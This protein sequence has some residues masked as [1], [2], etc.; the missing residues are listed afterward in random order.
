MTQNC[1]SGLYVALAITGSYNLLWARSWIESNCKARSVP[2]GNSLRFTTENIIPTTSSRKSSRSHTLLDF[3]IL[4][5]DVNVE[6]L[7]PY[8]IHVRG[9]RQVMCHH[10]KFYTPWLIP[11][12]T[13]FG[14]KGV[15]YRIR[16]AGT[17][18]VKDS[19]LSSD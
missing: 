3:S 15:F 12:A 13:Q 6:P 2:V 18:L 16:S 19:L 17:S 14:G 9:V 8:A 10:Q 5:C 4:W 11:V 7:S 1:S